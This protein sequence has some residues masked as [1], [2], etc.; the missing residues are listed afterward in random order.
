MI[1]ANG[2]RFST[3][4]LVLLVVQLSPKKRLDGSAQSISSSRGRTIQIDA[5]RFGENDT[6]SLQTCALLGVGPPSLRS[7]IRPAAFTMR[8]HG[9]SLALFNLDNAV[10]T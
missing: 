1:D 6:F 4:D 9:T 5:A 7:L 3:H 10:P 2:P 8:C